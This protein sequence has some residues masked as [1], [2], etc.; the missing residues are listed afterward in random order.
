MHH[1]TSDSL[2]VAPSKVTWSAT[3]G[4]LSQSNEEGTEWASPGQ[5]GSVTISASFDAYEQGPGGAR[6]PMGS[7]TVGAVV[8]VIGEGNDGG[9]EGND[10]G[11]VTTG[12]GSDGGDDAGEGGTG[13]GTPTCTPPGIASCPAG[14][15]LGASP[16][17]SGCFPNGTTLTNPITPPYD[18]PSGLCSDVGDVVIACTSS[19]S[20]SFCMKPTAAVPPGCSKQ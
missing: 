20:C 13:P 19:A 11:P 18:N 7:C 3:A 14:T 5:T 15:F 10:A 1:R 6:T 16:T 8:H 2:A 17:A 12:G 4:P 9:P